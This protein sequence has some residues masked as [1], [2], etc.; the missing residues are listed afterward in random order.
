M[1]DLTIAVLTYE[2]EALLPD[3]LKSIHDNLVDFPFAYEVL[4]VD[5]GSTVLTAPALWPQHRL[6]HLP[7][8][9]G[10]IG[11]MNKCFEYAQGNW[12]LFVANDVRLH[13]KALLSLWALRANLVQ[14]V[15]YQPDGAVDNAGLDWIWP[16]YGRRRRVPPMTVAPYLRLV[17][18]FA[19]T[20]FL[21]QRSVWQELGGFDEQLG[22]S[23]EDIDFAM[24]LKRNGYNCF[25]NAHASATHL[26]GQ[27]IGRVTKAPLKPYYHEARLKVLRK[28]YRGVDYWSRR[29][30]VG[31]IDG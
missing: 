8:N 11:G 15:L 29:L 3:C 28:H 5:N 23:H 26:M 22:I 31:L 18:S 4:I 16:G 2:G 17:P 13:P 12:V 6:R 10:N 25:V 20:C 27:T 30:A 21:L 1:I 9:V 7:T 24:R 14:P 19:A